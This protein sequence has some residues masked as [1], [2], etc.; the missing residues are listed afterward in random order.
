MVTTILEA[1]VQPENWGLLR[2]AYQ[3]DIGDLPPQM[4]RTF[5][6]QGLPDRTLWQIVSVW[7]SREALEDMRSS[8]ETPAGIRM[9]RT[10]GAEPVLTIFDVVTSAPD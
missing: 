2:E 9:F 7:K 4:V 8:G 6:L 3:R 1:V 5:L 10:A